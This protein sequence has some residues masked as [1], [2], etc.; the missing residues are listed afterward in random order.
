M[1]KYSASL[2]LMLVFT[3]LFPPASFAQSILQKMLDETNNGDTL[4]IEKSDYISD[5]SVSLTG[6]KDLTLI[7]E[8]GATV[9]CS[10]QF[11]DIFVIQNCTGIQIYNGTFK[12][13]LSEE[14]SSFGS[15][16]YLFQS[17][18]IRILNADIENNGIRGVFAQSVNGLELTKCCIR[19]NSASAFLF[20]ER[21]RNIVL[22]GNQYE[23]N[24]AYGD[25]IYAFKNNIPETDPFE[26][27]DER[28][29]NDRETTHLDSLFSQQKRVFP[30]IRKAF[31]NPT[32]LRAEYDSLNKQLLDPQIIETL[33]FPAWLEHSETSGN[34][35]VWLNLP[36]NVYRYLSDAS[37]L[38]RFDTRD[39]NEF[40]KYD[41]P[42]FTN[43]CPKT[44]L[45]GIQSDV[46]YLNETLPTTIHWNC[47]PE[48]EQMV[49]ELK[50]K[51]IRQIAEA[52]ETVIYRLLQVWEKYQTAGLL[53]EKLHFQL[54]GKCRFL[55]SEYNTETEF[56]DAHLLLDNYY[57]ATMRT[58]MKASVAKQLFFNRKDFTVYFT[59]QV[60]PGFK[61]VIFKSEIKNTAS[62][63]LPNLEPISDPSIE[64][65]NQLGL[66]FRFKAYGLLDQLWPDG[67][68]RRNWDKACP[69]PSN[70]NYQYL[71][72]GGINSFQTKGSAN[73]KIIVGKN[74]PHKSG[75]VINRIVHSMEFYS[76]SMGDCYFGQSNNAKRLMESLFPAELKDKQFL[77]YTLETE[78]D[79]E[80]V[81]K[82][83]IAKGMNFTESYSKGQ[84]LFCFTRQLK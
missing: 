79:A 31:H 45:K 75:D 15:C 21:N 80:I 67:F 26:S 59:M 39:A 16:F 36:E 12:H 53:Y 81:K 74:T 10:S 24:G 50:N 28:A 68:S 34:H 22:K 41:E 9:T 82:A 5:N 65:M 64:C 69:T 14:A 13:R 25:E 23:N 49:L 55:Q 40:F 35:I 27:I 42:D 83:L 18:N 51:N 17:Q 58:P 62:W 8:E 77:I 29:L 70:K 48:L 4:Y 60:H 20:Q 1:S 38:A 76:K 33:V 78:A 84:I 2:Y 46:V 63:T 52:Q 44:F 11:Q 71:L 30:Q 6:R 72:L 61:Q 66:A 7:F 19:N 47:D 32:V 37:G 73:E 43:I 57:L 56:L 54:V 3:C